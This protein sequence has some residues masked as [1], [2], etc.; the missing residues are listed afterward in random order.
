MVDLSK[1]AADCLRLK[2]LPF[3]LWVWRVKRDSGRGQRFSLIGLVWP[4][5]YLFMIFLKN[6]IYGLFSKIKD[7]NFFV[8]LVFYFFF[9]FFFFWG[10]KLNSTGLSGCS[11]VYSRGFKTIFYFK[12]IKYIIFSF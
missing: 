6:L 2:W 11:N 10:L 1:I 3:F 9:F 7:Q 12:N 5:F 4:F 8:G